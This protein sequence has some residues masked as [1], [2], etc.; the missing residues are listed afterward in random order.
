VFF[1]QANSEQ[2]ASPSHCRQHSRDRLTDY[3][4]YTRRAATADFTKKREFFFPGAGEKKRS[5]VALKKEGS[6]KNIR[7]P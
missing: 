3:P 2:P 6:R 4:F 1:F 7:R 5:S